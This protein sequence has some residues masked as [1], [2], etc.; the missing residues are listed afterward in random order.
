MDA[1]SGFVGGDSTQLAVELPDGTQAG[2]VGWRAFKAG[3]P[4]GGCLE[5]GALLFPSI[6]AGALPGDSG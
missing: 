6:A 1:H 5:I 3:G 4:E 2:I